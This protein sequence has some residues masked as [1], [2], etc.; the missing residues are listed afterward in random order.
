MACRTAPIHQPAPAPPFKKG[1]REPRGRDSWRT[2][3]ES[4]ISRSPEP[5]CDAI[6][7]VN[8]RRTEIAHPRLLLGRMWG[9]SLRATSGHP[10]SHG[11][12]I[13]GLGRLSP[14]S[15]PSSFPAHRFPIP[16]H[17]SQSRPPSSVPSPH[18]STSTSTSKPIT[19][20]VLFPHHRRPCSA[21][22]PILRH[23]RSIHSPGGR[24]GLTTPESARVGLHCDSVTSP[25]R[26]PIQYGI[27]PQKATT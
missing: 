7:R 21:N 15:S 6:C 24:Q 14:Y 27:F 19:V 23:S 1:P 17:P 26:L 22:C 3:S 9:I 20:D 25:I 10:Q 18:P 2:S 4:H 8:G 5:F 11:V 16:S 12:P 13:P